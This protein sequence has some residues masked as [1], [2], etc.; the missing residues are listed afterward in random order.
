MELV[1][2]RWGVTPLGVERGGERR[3]KEGSRD[4]LGEN[5]RRD[6]GSGTFGTGSGNR[7]KEEASEEVG[8]KGNVVDR[9]STV[10]VSYP[11]VDCNSS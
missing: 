3:E 5:G 4:R 8:R 7:E 10:N 2:R 9:L 11:R 1:T 6:R